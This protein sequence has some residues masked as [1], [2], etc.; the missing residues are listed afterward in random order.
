MSRSSTL[1]N[2]LH[3]YSPFDSSLKSIYITPPP[4]LFTVERNNVLDRPQQYNLRHHLCRRYS[5][6]NFLYLYKVV[7]LTIGSGG[8]AACITAG[9]LAEADPSLKIL[10]SVKQFGASIF[11]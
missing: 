3:S 4:V 10:V 8:A 1:N 9:R 2:L 7:V 6:F 11:F 5:A